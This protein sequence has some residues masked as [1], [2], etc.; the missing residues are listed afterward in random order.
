[1]K[2]ITKKIIILI[3]ACILTIPNI[4]AIDINS[5]HAIL[6]NMN[7]DK[8]IYEKMHMNE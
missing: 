4:K 3:L 5:N 7:E 1:M 2:I 8:I 6:Y